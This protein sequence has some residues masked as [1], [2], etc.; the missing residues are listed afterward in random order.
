MNPPSGF[1]HE[2]HEAVN[3][4]SQRLGVLR[5]AAGD[6]EPRQAATP[7]GQHDT[8]TYVIKTDVSRTSDN[9]RSFRY[10][11]I[12]VKAEATD[13]HPA[14][15]EVY[16]E[17]IVVGFWTK[18]AFSGA[19]PQKRVNEL[20]ERVIKLQDAVKFAREEA[21]GIEVTDQSIGEKVFGYLLR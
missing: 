14:Q 2:Q 15:V 18:V 1:L 17:E 16:Y 3:V 20:L 11:D 12:P 13:K 21:N 8:K 7:F 5:P 19:V 6:R 10:R 4:G 9:R